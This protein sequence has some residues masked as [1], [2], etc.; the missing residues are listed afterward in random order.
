MQFG[1]TNA[2]ATFII[3]RLLDPLRGLV[4]I[5]NFLGLK[6]KMYILKETKAMMLPI[7]GPL[8]I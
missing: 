4:R 5:P 6:L 3:R 1:L 7:F 8:F 2:L